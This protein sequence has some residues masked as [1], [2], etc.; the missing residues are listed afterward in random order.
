MA[1]IFFLNTQFVLGAAMV[2][3]FTGPN[4]LAT[5]LLTVTAAEQNYHGSGNI[6]FCVSSPSID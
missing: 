5:P 1:V 4:K 2:F 6:S 3:T